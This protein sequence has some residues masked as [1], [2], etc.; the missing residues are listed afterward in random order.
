MQPGQDRSGPAGLPMPL[1]SAQMVLPFCALKCAHIWSEALHQAKRLVNVKPDRRRQRASDRLRAIEALLEI[2]HRLRFAR[3]VV[4]FQNR[5]FRHGSSFPPRFA[6]LYLLGFCS[7]SA[8]MRSGL[9]NAV[10]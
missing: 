5:L 1:S 6:L 2:R 3:I 9:R 7:L 10:S 4:K 8:E